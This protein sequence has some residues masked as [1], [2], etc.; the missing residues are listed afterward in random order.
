[1]KSELFSLLDRLERERTLSLAEYE[2]PGAYQSLQAYFAVT[3][4]V[5]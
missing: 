3:H 2:E 1:M 5:L 4:Q